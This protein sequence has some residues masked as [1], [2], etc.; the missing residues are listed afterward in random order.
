LNGLDFS[1][2]AEL[3]RLREA[4][5]SAVTM[6]T[7]AQISASGLRGGVHWSARYFARRSAWH[8]LDHAWEIEDRIV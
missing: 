5:L 2:Q 4:I 6:E 3:A 7:L 1:S 8:L